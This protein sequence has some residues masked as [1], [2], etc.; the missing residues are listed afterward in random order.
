MQ[1]GRCRACRFVRCG[2]RLKF[3]SKLTGS[4]AGAGAAPSV[5]G[6][7]ATEVLRARAAACGMMSAPAAVVSAPVNEWLVS[8]LAPSRSVTRG[9]ASTEGRARLPPPPAS[10]LCSRRV[11]GNQTEPLCDVW[12]PRWRLLAQR[13]AA[14]VPCAPPGVRGSA[15]S[16]KPWRLQSPTSVDALS[17]RNLPLQ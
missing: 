4:I 9:L 7:G 12:I 10:P 1:N 8:R 2:P 14:A 16:W 11:A 3:L 17:T 13:A 6:A 5:A 15:G